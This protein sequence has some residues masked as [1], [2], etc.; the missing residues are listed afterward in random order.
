M[1]AFL[2]YSLNDRDQF[3]LT[4]L[5]KELSAKGFSINQSNDFNMQMSQLTKVNISKSN[6]FIGLI[7]GKGYE[8]NRIENEW[9]V[10][11]NSRIPSILIIENNVPINNGFNYPYII[12]DRNNPHQAISELNRK[13]NEMKKASNDDSNAWAWVL[14]GA[15]LISLLSLLNKDEK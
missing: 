10:A 8:K 7:S 13:I 9:S 4:L 14:G 6:L 1:R 12:F 5:A 11:Y 3:I 2:S 15:A